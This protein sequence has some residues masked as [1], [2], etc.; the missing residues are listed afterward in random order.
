MVCPFCN[1]Y[2]LKQFQINGR[3]A[4]L[5]L[6]DHLHNDIN[7]LGVHCDA[8]ELPDLVNPE[9]DDPKDKLLFEKDGSISSTDGRFAHTINTCKLNRAELNDMRFNILQKFREDIVAQL[10]LHKSPTDMK[11]AIRTLI[12]QMRRQSEDPM[13]EFTAFRGFM[14]RQWVKEEIMAVIR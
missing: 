1:Q 14:L 7:R 4:T 5:S 12:D 9:V 2:K 6:F 13:I 8:L 3:Q 11:T 10:V